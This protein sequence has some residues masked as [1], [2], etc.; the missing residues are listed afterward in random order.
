MSQRKSDVWLCVRDGGD[1]AQVKELQVCAKCGVKTWCYLDPKSREVK[2]LKILHDPTSL[3]REQREREVPETIP[4]TIKV[5]GATQVSVDN[6]P[7]E[8]EA[9]AEADIDTDHTREGEEVILVDNSESMVN[10]AE[11]EKLA[12]IERLKAQLAALESEE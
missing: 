8:E 2:P 1:T 7:E 5:E 11:R 12:E 3:L 9:P 10:I 4:E 6:V